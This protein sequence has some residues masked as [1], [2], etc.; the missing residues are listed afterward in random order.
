MEHILRESWHAVRIYACIFISPECQKFLLQI[1]ARLHVMMMRVS[2]AGAYT[3]QGITRFDAGCGMSGYYFTRLPLYRQGAAAEHRRRRCK[4]SRR[5]AA[6][7]LYMP[8]ESMM[9]TMT[10]APVRAGIGFSG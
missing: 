2:S 4:A 10:M 5:S 8:M 7:A 6:E 9:M 1:R 3:T